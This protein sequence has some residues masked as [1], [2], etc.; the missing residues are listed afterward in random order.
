VSNAIRYTHHGE[1]T[2][3]ANAGPFG[4]DSWVADTGQGI[5]PEFV[6]K[7]FEK[8]GTTGYDPKQQGLGLAIV[9]QAVEAHGGSVRV[10]SR[11]GAGST[12][13]FFIPAKTDST[14]A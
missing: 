10:D 8:F 11:I 7:V 2:V 12:F 13:S 5:A 14:A 9:K 6:E 1:I 4:V 3:G